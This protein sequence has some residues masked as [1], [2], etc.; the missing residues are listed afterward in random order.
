MWLYIR[1]GWLNPF[2]LVRPMTPD[3]RRYLDNLAIRAE[4]RQAAIEEA[5][6]QGRR[7]LAL[8][9]FESRRP[10]EEVLQIPRRG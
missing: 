7:E 10:V 8:R 5:L 2:P 9:L 1:G 6:R 4:T 3:L